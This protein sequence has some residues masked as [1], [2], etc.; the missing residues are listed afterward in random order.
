MEQFQKMYVA[1]GIES[2]VGSYVI[3]AES[4]ITLVYDLSEMLRGNLVRGDVEGE[5][6]EGQFLKRGVFPLCLPVCG[7]RG[8]LFGDEE[9]S[10]LGQSFEDDIL[11]RETI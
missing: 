2:H 4:G 5:D 9:T 3:N 11:K 8:N 10:V 7:Q 6:V 1:C